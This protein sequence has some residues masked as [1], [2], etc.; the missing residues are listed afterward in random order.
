M[1]FPQKLSFSEAQMLNCF[2]SPDVFTLGP[3]KWSNMQSKTRCPLRE[4]RS[5]YSSCPPSPVI[6]T[7]LLMCVW[8]KFSDTQCLYSLALPLT[9]G[10]KLCCFS[11]THMVSIPLLALVW[12][13]CTV[14]WPP[15]PGSTSCRLVIHG[16]LYLVFSVQLVL[17]SS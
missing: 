8:F 13:L 4:Q 10:D 12:Y 6:K 2:A 14:A 7:G 11:T 17:T 15:S 9:C 16:I 3:L 1:C 5:T